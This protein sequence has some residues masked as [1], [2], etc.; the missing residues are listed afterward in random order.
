MDKIL[1]LVTDPYERKARAT[2]ALMAVLPVVVP[3][4]CQFGAKNPIL[5]AIVGLLGTCGAIY[6][7]ASIARGR[8]KLIETKLVEAWGGMPTTILLRH[9]DSFYD[10]ETK[11]RYHL[12]ALLRLGM[13]MPTEAQEAAD[14]RKADDA[15]G[16]VARRLRELTRTDKGL[17]FKENTAYGFHRNMLGIK[18][19]GILFSILG[20]FYG[21]VLAGA[22][23]LDP[24]SFNP[25]SLASPGLSGGLSFLVGLAM[26]AIWLF[27]FN[28]RQVRV[29]G[30][31]YAERLFE[32]LP[33]QKKLP[34][35][36]A[37]A[38]TAEIPFE[39]PLKPSA[40]GA[41]SPT[42]GP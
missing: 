26:L 41:T 15:Y 20:I 35:A 14:P 23:K 16:A 32:K 3:L 36:K 42:D 30:N 18:P 37:P 27:Y 38:A 22:I 33:Q 24:P 2:P 28:P 19:I 12:D 29:I 13:T 5:T 34:G 21:L 25:H 39:A 9:R 1:D 11:K 17:L 7:G 8:G 6:A 31:V 40:G 10:G 4:V